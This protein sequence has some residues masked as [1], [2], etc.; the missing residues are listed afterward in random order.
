MPGQTAMIILGWCGGAVRNREK[1]IQASEGL[2]G[3]ATIATQPLCGGWR[4]YDEGGSMVQT[5]QLPFQL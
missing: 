2:I 4:G 5:L 3:P 1:G